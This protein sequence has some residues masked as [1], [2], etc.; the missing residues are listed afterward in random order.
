MGC[1]G[2][3][4]FRYCGRKRKN[5]V[6]PLQGETSFNTDTQPAKLHSNNNVRNRFNV[7]KVFSEYFTGFKAGEI[8]HRSPT[9]TRAGIP[10][11]RLDTFPTFQIQLRSMQ[12][13]PDEP[14]ADAGPGIKPDT[15]YIGGQILESA[16]KHRGGGVVTIND[17]PR[18]PPLHMCKVLDRVYENHQNDV[19]RGKTVLRGQEIGKKRQFAAKGHRKPFVFNSPVLYYDIPTPTKRDDFGMGDDES[20]THSNAGNTSTDVEGNENI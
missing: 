13:G 1:K 10:D 14:I 11:G 19:Y 4:P 20:P 18:L 3:K 8:T 2:S 17:L 12:K 5:R 7:D 9:P 15:S 6:E 16:Q